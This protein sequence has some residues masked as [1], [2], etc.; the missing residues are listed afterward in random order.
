MGS[1]ICVASKPFIECRCHQ[2]FL[3]G[4]ATITRWLYRSLHENKPYDR[5]VRELVSPVPGSE[6]FTKGII[7][8][9][10]VNASQ[11]PP[12]QAAQPCCRAPA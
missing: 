3:G 8:R 7:W 10:V 2:H 6:G 9:G 11:A 5:F 12:V 1:A 4:R